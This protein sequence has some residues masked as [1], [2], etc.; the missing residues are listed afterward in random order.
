MNAGRV[1]M[2]GPI[3]VGLFAVFVLCLLTGFWGATAQLSGAVIAG[4]VIEVETKKHE[5]EHPE[6]GVIDAIYVRE[7]DWVD[8][9]DPLFQ[10]NGRDLIAEYQVLAQRY[11]DLLARASR[12][13]G[14]SLNKTEIDWADFDIASAGFSG[15]DAAAIKRDQSEYHT[16]RL[17]NQRSEQ[18]QLQQQSAQL[19]EQMKGLL[20]Y[21]DALEIQAALVQSELGKLSILIRN[22]LATQAEEAPLRREEAQLAGEIGKVFAQIGE[23]LARQAELSVVRT[24]MQTSRQEQAISDLKHAN[25]EMA[26]IWPRLKRLEDRI[27]RLT[28]LSPSEGFVFA[29]QVVA[30]QSV[31]AAGAPAMFIVPTKQ[32]LVI[33]AK[34]GARDIE[35]IVVGQAAR[36]K[37]TGLNHRITPELGGEVTIISADILSDEQS[38]DAYYQVY[39]ALTDDAA[40]DLSEGV[41]K[42]GMPVEVFFPTS[43]RTPL[44]YL[45][46][47]MSD[48][49]KRAWRES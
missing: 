15:L 46:Q 37:M 8:L 44:S 10:L 45:V 34:V 42:P 12:L 18:S 43:P 16:I 11:F 14:E 23:I 47:P 28:L 27:D 38:G 6:G 32:P 19:A 1:S 39:L 2:L 17:Q 21:K 3:C 9:G 49:F 26:E 20:A 24:R 4:G 36:I 35:H 48:Y 31:I 41:L 29:S 25:M 22:G 13:Q 7:G 5:V 30:P 40:D 33:S